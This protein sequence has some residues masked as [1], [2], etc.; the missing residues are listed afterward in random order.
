MFIDNHKETIQYHK[1]THLQ[2]CLKTAPCEQW[3][4]NICTIQAINTVGSKD[5]ILSGFN[6]ASIN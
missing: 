6:I 5:T 3:L 1:H 4:N 2:L